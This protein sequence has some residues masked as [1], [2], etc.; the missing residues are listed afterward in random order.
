MAKKDSPQDMLDI[1]QECFLNDYE[2]SNEQLM[3][4]LAFIYKEL[5]K[6]KKEK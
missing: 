4:H 6:L 1:L 3:Y 2:L 5:I